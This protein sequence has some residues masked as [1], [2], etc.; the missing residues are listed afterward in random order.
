MAIHE[1]MLSLNLSDFE[2]LYEI[3][4]KRRKKVTISNNHLRALLMDHGKAIA[5]L[6]E[7]GIKCVEP[8]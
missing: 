7:L 8:E 6:E 4:E 1:L 2:G 3:A 5:K